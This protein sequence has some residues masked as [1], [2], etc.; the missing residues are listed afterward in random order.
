MIF[1]PI[2]VNVRKVTITDYE[3]GGT[4]RSVTGVIYSFLANLTDITTIPRMTWTNVMIGPQVTTSEPW[5]WRTD[6]S[7]KE[8]C[9]EVEDESDAG[10][11]SLKTEAKKSWSSHAD[12]IYKRSRWFSL[13]GI[14]RDILERIQESTKLRRVEIRTIHDDMLARMFATGSAELAR[15]AGI[16]HDYEEKTDREPIGRTTLEKFLWGQTDTIPNWAQ[17]RYDQA[18]AGGF[19][20]LQSRFEPQDDF[21]SHE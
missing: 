5:I 15:I 2:D 7:Q 18:L 19:R 4:C 8:V 20:V 1:P 9:M 11:S 16:L 12:E 14:H 6:A 21:V 13:I 17:A 3:H 10:L